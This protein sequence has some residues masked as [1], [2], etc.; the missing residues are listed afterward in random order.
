MTQKTT[1]TKFLLLKIINGN[2]IIKIIKNN[3][4][5]YD[6]YYNK[7]ILAYKIQK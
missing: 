3:V 1:E 7:Y 4:Y 6:K 5:K 2:K